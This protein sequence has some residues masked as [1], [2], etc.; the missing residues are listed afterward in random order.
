MPR[1]GPPGDP[2]TTALLELARSLGGLDPLAHEPASV[3]RPLE[4]SD[5]A[6]PDA[7]A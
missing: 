5:D 3:F 1:E 6:D 2:A 4:P 7:D